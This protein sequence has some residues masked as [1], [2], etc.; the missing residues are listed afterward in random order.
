M[1]KKYLVALVSLILA[2]SC[3][4]FSSLVEDIKSKEQTESSQSKIQQLV[5]EFFAQE[6]KDNQFRKIIAHAEQP[7]SQGCVPNDP[8][9]IDTACDLLG[10]FGCDSIK[11]V[12]EMS[13][14]CRGNSNGLCLK[15]AC[16]FLGTFGCDNGKE[17]KQVAPSCIGNLDDNCLIS[18]CNRLGTFG[19]DSI[20]EVTE[21]ARACGG[22]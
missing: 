14:A 11:E 12:T 15:A 19:C 9:C 7:L 5:D 3:L 10:T 21:V 1:N 18:V 4:G 22:Q 6:R 20:T 2:Y 13:R 8:S 17:I 16:D